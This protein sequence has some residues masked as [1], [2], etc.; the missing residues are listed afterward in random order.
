MKSEKEFKLLCLF[1]YN[2]ATGFATVSHSIIDRLRTH[3]GRRLIMDII[4]INYI[5]KDASG[6]AIPGKPYYLDEEKRQC[7]VPAIQE[8]ANQEDPLGRHEFLHRL[9]TIDFNLVFIIQDP[10]V[11]AGRTDRFGVRHGDLLAEMKQIKAKKRANN[12]KQFKTIFYFP[13]DGEPLAEWF[14]NFDV[15]DAP[16]AYT[17]Y[18]R[19]EVV[20]VRENLR[21]KIRVIPHGINEEDFHPMPAEMVSEFRE[22]Y[23]GRNAKKN[24]WGNVNR[25]QTRKDIPSTIFAFAKYQEMYDPEAFLYLHMMPTDPQ[26]WNLN[27][28]LKQTSLVEGVDYMFQQKESRDI[29]KSMLNMIYN[30][31]D[32]YITTTTGEGWGL[33]ITE[34]MACR[35]PVLAPY[36]TSIL[37][38]SGGKDARCW[39]EDNLRLYCSHFD[40]MV[41]E[42]V[43]YAA[44]P[45]VMNMAWTFKEETQKKIDLAYKYTQDLAWNSVCERWIDQF[46]KLL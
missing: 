10:G 25:N 11:M 26:G 27:T 33:S 21:G 31:L 38:I 24:I 19:N 45:R 20:A 42:A 37:D 18:G 8:H 40:N 46:E 7:V 9:R 16:V 39:T 23:F 15:I 2:A 22:E 44:L 29:S 17:N 4:A 1:D 30:S 34:A 5:D 35:I 43:D 12:E 28:V 3:F 32:F 6:N 14:D 41:R 13:I 36:H